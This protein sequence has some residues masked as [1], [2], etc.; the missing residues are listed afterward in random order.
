MIENAES[1]PQM[2][3]SEVKIK[4]GRKNDVKKTWESLYLEL[5]LKEC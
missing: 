3:L 1:T 5:G 4:L 2:V